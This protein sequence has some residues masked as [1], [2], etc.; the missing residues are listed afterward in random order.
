M[1]L[2]YDINKSLTEINRGEAIGYL[3]T[4]INN[5]NEDVNEY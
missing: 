4:I 1:L 3:Y 2:T 5:K